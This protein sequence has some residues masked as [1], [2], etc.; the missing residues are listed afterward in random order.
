M[1]KVIKIN[2][3]V[4]FFLSSYYASKAGSWKEGVSTR[5]WDCC[6]P[7]CGW[8]GKAFF[9]KPVISCNVYGNHIAYNAQN[10]CK[11]KGW[12]YT[13]PD[14]RP[15]VISKNMSYGFAAVNLKDMQEK[16]WCCKCYRL[17]FQ[18]YK[19]SY[20]EM[21]VQITNTGG[22]LQSNHFDIAIPGG[23]EGL[24]QGCTKQ[25]SNFSGG[26]RYGG[27][28]SAKECHLLPKKLVQGCLWRFDWFMN[29]NNPRILFQEVVCP[30]ILTNITKCKRTTKYK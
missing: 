26:S 15:F 21:I 14:Q 6:K 11:T 29:T 13:C 27:V 25:Y 8:W 20:K 30:E 12:A 24:F 18:H 17:K 2:V 10:G 23:G 22:D 28:S 16:D 1:N 19:L 4:I 3:Y 7:S 5:Y 9:T